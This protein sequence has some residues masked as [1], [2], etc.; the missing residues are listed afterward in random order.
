MKITRRASVIAL[1]VLVSWLPGSARESA[2]P[3][4]DV[5]LQLASSLFDASRYTEALQAFER[6][7]RAKDDASGV[8]A[9]KGIIRSA[10]RMSRF[11]LARS[12]A[13]ALRAMAPMDPDALT[14]FADASWAAGRFDES[15]A[16]Y[17]EALSLS[18]VLPRARLGIGRALAT[19]QRLQEALSEV[20]AARSLLP[21]DPDVPLA[22]ADLYRR[23]GRFAEAADAYAAAANLLPR[24]RQDGR[25]AWARSQARFLDSFK[26]TV[27]LEMSEAD[28]LATHTVPFRLDGDKVV[29]AVRVNGGAP[30][31]FILD[32]G[33]EQT[34]LTRRT[35]ERE[36]V[37]TQGDSR[38]GG[39]GSGGPSALQMAKVRSLDI[40]SLQV[41]N[42][43]VL[44]QT[45]DDRSGMQNLSPL[46]LGLSVTIDYRAKTVTFARSLP[47]TAAAHRLP[48][49]IERLPMVRGRVNASSGLYFVVDTGGNLTTIG[50]DVAREIGLAGERRIPLRVRGV[51]GRDDSAFLVP[52]MDLDLAPIA[53]R[54]VPLAVL[55][56]RAPSEMLGFRLGGILGHRFL[57]QYRVSMDLARAELRLEPQTP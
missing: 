57:S 36:R 11:E 2:S 10:L 44:F 35:A 26:G 19:R 45:V 38:G 31:E 17:R 22:A 46:S 52:G 42:V 6:V 53:H 30:T 49:V 14:I 41:R 32:T 28:A 47:E 12:E 25:A 8:T 48:L 33:A 51:S 18:P 56:L 3:D 29:V 54:K 13:V 21:A 43:P 50:A 16:A 55:D 27:P 37:A 34:I 9:R 23:L 7:A 24:N 5:D 40:G 4:L 1:V 15:E 39:I 20:L